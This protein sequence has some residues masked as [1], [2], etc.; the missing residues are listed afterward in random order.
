MTPVQ[1]TE[2]LLIE[3]LMSALDA[4]ENAKRCSSSMLVYLADMMVQRAKDELETVKGCQARIA[5]C[6]EA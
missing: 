5:D 1:Q 3:V 4:R 2:T 6:E